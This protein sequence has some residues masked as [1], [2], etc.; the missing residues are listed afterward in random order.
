MPEPARKCA[1]D[2]AGLQFGPGRRQPW[3]PASVPAAPGRAGVLCPKPADGG[4]FRVGEPVLPGRPIV[5]ASK[6][7]G[8][9]QGRTT[10]RQAAIARTPY[11]ESAGSLLVLREQRPPRSLRG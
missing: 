8:S 6:L 2:R 11:R 9:R 10:S 1:A 5:L 3:F 4:A 7:A